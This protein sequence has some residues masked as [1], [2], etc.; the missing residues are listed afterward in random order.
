L[1][2]RDNI[3]FPDTT[4]PI[5]A[6]VLDYSTRVRARVQTLDVACLGIGGD[7]HLAS[8][9]PPFTSEIYD[10]AHDVTKH[11][12]HTTQDRGFAVKDRITVSMDVICRARRKL[13]FINSQ[14]KMDL[15]RNMVLSME[16]DA[17]LKQPILQVIMSGCVTV[18]CT[19]P[20]S[21]RSTSRP[22]SPMTIKEHLNVVVFGASGDLAKKKTFPAL[23]SLHS[24]GLLP[25]SVNIIGY[26]RSKISE[27]EFWENFVSPSLG[28]LPSYFSG[29]DDL[30]ICGG[31]VFGNV[32]RFKSSVS[33]VSGPYEHDGLNSEESTWSVHS[34]SN[35][36][37][38]I[39]VETFN[40]FAL[41]AHD[42]P[43]VQLRCNHLFY[44]AL[45]PGV[46][47]SVVKAAKE[48][49]WSTTGWNR[50]VVEKPFG[51]DSASSEL[52]SSELMTLLR[53]DQIYRIDHY[54]GK[55]MALN[56]M[57]MRFANMI[58]APLWSKT[59]ISSVKVTFKETITVAGRAGYFDE[60]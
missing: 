1:I 58:F 22:S 50:Y 11:C 6:C 8:W 40:K 43:A 27:E 12:Q 2:P 48:L 29:K 20:F 55:E 54:L 47:P 30:L 51:K 37:K 52:L 31:D 21:L 16:P 59:S 26:A 35:K 13:F 53:E 36:L 25:E 17:L 41:E 28:K 15:W 19:P 5:D 34:L 44:L 46:F 23:F 56:I 32:A 24:E 7:G 60:C 10:I 49:C 38:D 45:P 4:L 57:S 33:Y 14:A 9:F 39:E 42:A 3:I 18:V